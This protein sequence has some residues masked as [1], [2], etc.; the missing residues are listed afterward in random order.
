MSSEPVAFR[1]YLA[2]RFGFYF[3]IVNREEQKSCK[4]IENVLLAIISLG[5]VL[6]INK[7]LNTMC[8]LLH[9]IRRMVLQFNILKFL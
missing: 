5:Y 6:F 7:Q 9:K 1:P 8:N 2:M 4:D 3:R